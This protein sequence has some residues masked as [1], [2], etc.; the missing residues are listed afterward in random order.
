MSDQ[1]QNLIMIAKETVQG[2]DVDVPLFVKNNL[3][4][5]IDTIVSAPN[6]VG[7]EK[8]IKALRHHIADQYDWQAEYCNKIEQ[9]CDRAEAI[10][11]GIQRESI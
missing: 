7:L 8:A 2:F 1:I 11:K 3:N 9:I 10:R 6:E 5:F 4:S